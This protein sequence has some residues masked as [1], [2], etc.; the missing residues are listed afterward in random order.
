MQVIVVGA[1]IAGLSMA[2]SLHQMGIQVQVY[3]AVTRLAPLGVGINIQPSAVRELDEL[4]LADAM[5]ATGHPI[6]EL[7]YY[8]RHGQLVWGEMRGVQAGFNWPQFAFHRGRLQM[9]LLEAVRSRIGG[10]N[11]LLGHRLTGLHEEAG[12]VVA[13]FTVADG[14]QIEAR[15][16][17]LVGADGI[18]S[19]VRRHFYPDEGA[20]HFNRQVLWRA[21]T[22]IPTYLEGGTMVVCGH[23]ARRVVIYPIA[24]LHDGTGRVLTNWIV[25]TDVANE[26]PPP[27][28]WNRKVGKD[29]P[30]AAVGDWR[31]DWLDLRGMIEGTE[32][33][34]EFPL[35][36]R[37][38]VQR[39]SF[40]RVTL[41]GDAAHPMQPTGSQAG[42]QAIIDGRLLTQLLVDAGNVEDALARYDAQRRPQMNDVTLINR[43]FGPEAALQLAEDR[44]PNGFARIEDVLSRDE[45]ERFPRE[46][47]AATGMDPSMVNDRPSFVVP[48]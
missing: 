19:A 1:G 2:L 13:R 45:L 33:I 35:V 30:L 14:E 20:P 27:E 12:Q 29:S 47:R 42:T 7:R 8:N 46:F 43:S 6:R 48:T 11:V 21:A 5:A 31:M 16:D 26:L 44:A 22:P 23:F 32:E 28:D 37:H 18:Q 10:E 36:D 24:P 41:I 17:V 34:M 15:G 3:E 38:P 25:Q 9:M 4:G 40:G 39:W